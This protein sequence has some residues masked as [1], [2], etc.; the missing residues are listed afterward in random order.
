MEVG[1]GPDDFVLDGD[2]LSL[3][4]KGAETSPPK[5]FSAHVCHGQTAGWITIILGTEVG[6]S[7]GVLVVLDR[8]PAP[9]PK[10]GQSP[11]PIFGP[12]LLWP[13]GWMPQDATW[14]EARPQPRG[15]CVRWD[16]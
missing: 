8:D 1:L 3:P 9:S 16:T 12:I 14:Y 11:F 4:K 13:N 2:P 7:Q 5:N 6:L 10:R 15:L